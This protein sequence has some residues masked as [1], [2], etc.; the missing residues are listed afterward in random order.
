LLQVELLT[1]TQRAQ[2]LSTGPM[3]QLDPHSC[4][5]RIISH[6]VKEMGEH[7]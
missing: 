7:R 6:E 1:P 3:A 4:E 5:E 2:L